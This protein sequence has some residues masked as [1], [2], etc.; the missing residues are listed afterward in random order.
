MRNANLN[1]ESRRGRD[2][3][4]EQARIPD[5][6]AVVQDLRRVGEGVAEVVLLALRTMNEARQHTGDSVN[7]QPASTGKAMRR[8]HKIE[9]ATA[10]QQ[11]LHSVSA[12]VHQ[13]NQGVANPQKHTAEQNA[14]AISL[15][16][17]IDKGLTLR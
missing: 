7:D 2:L 1:G 6:L 3:R 10:M 8:S 14:L 15:Q 16:S 5:D 4:S 11:T 9:Q 13:S 17:D 12:G